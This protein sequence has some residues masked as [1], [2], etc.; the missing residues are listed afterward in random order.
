MVR[1]AY[2]F[3]PHAFN[4]LRRYMKF[5]VLPEPERAEAIEI[6]LQ[7]SKREEGALSIQP[8]PLRVLEVIRPLTLSIN[9]LATNCR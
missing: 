3:D 1:T 4:N 6:L 8:H 9:N 7:I 2:D 5:F